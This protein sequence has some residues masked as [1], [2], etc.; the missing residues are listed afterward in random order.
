LTARAPS[1]SA[2]AWV[3]RAAEEIVRR[4]EAIRAWLLAL[5]ESD[6]AAIRGWLVK[7]EED[8]PVIVEEVLNRCRSE[9]DAR[10]YYLMRASE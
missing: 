8:D 4:K 6:E 7:I 2:K 9:P 5:T 10:A 3:K 1:P